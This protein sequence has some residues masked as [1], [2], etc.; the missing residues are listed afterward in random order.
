MERDANRA[1]GAVPVKPLDGGHQ[2]TSLRCGL[3]GKDQ[4]MAERK[5]GEVAP[6]FFLLL[7]VF[8]SLFALGPSCDKAYSA[9][10]P[11]TVSYFAFSAYAVIDA[12]FF[13]MIFITAS[14]RRKYWVCE[15]C[16]ARYEKT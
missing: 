3:C 2:A 16:G 7:F 13:C 4:A 12:M 5:T 8:F 11:E 6:A 9:T 1:P 14:F 15:I 10:A